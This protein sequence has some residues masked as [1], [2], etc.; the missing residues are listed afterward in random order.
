MC[1]LRISRAQNVWTSCLHCGECASL[2]RMCGECV[3]EH[4]AVCGER[5][6]AAPAAAA[7]EGE[8]VRLRG[9]KIASQ[10]PQAAPASLTQPRAGVP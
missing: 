6:S 3:E 5:D 8:P 9:L 1:G 4:R 7:A 10:A 2:W